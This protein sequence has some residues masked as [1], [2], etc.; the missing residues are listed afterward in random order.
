M[1][2]YKYIGTCFAIIEQIEDKGIIIRFINLDRL[3][4][5]ED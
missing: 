1:R 3:D 2:Y 4:K 5:E